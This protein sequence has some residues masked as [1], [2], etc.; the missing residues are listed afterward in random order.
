MLNQCPGYRI[1]RRIG[2][3]G[4]I[5]EDIHVVARSPQRGD[6]THDERFRNYRKRADEERDLQTV[7]IFRC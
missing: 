4:R 7:Q 2:W 3:P 5:G 1:Q 6:L